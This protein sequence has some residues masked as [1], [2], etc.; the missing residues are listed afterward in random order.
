MLACRAGRGHALHDAVFSGAMFGGA[1]FHGAVFHGAVFGGA[2]F[3]AGCAA[4]R[5]RAGPE[6]PWAG[7]PSA[8]VPVVDGATPVP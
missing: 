1:A 3:G 2:V 8:T 4:S 6:P 5:V 7:R